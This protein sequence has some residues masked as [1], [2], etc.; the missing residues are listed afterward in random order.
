MP[1]ATVGPDD[2]VIA[3]GYLH[4]A[5]SETGQQAVLLATTAASGRCRW[6]ASRAP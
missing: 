2:T 1:A 4:T 5:A 3:A 6:P